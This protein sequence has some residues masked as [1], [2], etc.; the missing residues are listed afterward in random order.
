M[1]RLTFNPLVA[2]FLDGR[3]VPDVRAVAA[4]RNRG[5]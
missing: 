4:Y 1:A 2:G 3:G 5:Q